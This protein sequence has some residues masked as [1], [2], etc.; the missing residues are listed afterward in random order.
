MLFTLILLAV[1]AIPALAVLLLHRLVFRSQNVPAV[2]DPL[3]DWS[4]DRY[5]PML[6]LLD[7]ADFVFLRGQPGF[8]QN[9]EDRLRAQR[10]HLFRAYLR[11]LRADFGRIALAAKLLMVEARSDRPD[12]AAALIRS[13]LMFGWAVAV[14]NLRL[15]L[16]SCGWGTVSANALLNTFDRL[17]TEF[18]ALVPAAATSVA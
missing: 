18:E 6:R 10:S 14:V 3:D 8:T 17:R 5:R 13:E 16:Y 15:A 7:G 9:L 11:E 12:L 1:S 2:F 4:I